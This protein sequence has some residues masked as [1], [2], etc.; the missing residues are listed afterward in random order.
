MI[1]WSVSAIDSKLLARLTGDPRIV[2]CDLVSVSNKPNNTS[3]VFIPH[4]ISSE[5]LWPKSFDHISIHF[6]F[7]VSKFCLNSSAATIA[8]WAPL[9]WSS[10]LKL[11]IISV[12]HL[13]YPPFLEYIWVTCRVVFHTSF[14]FTL[15][16]WK[17]IL[18]WSD[19]VEYLEA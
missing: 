2:T 15:E 6:C 1:I 13:T 4:L 5:M 16:Y 9:T 19:F 17:E 12:N 7:I 14:I 18:N 10:L 11:K 3:P 8:S